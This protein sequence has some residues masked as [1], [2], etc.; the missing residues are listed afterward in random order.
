MIIGPTA[1]GK[2]AL[3]VEM[4]HLLGRDRC[5]VLA[6]D[7]FQIYRGMDIGTAKP[8]ME[9]RRGVEHL[10]IDL[11]D[12]TGRFT[13]HQWLVLA[14]QTIARVQARGG[15]PIVVGGTNLYVKALLDGLFEGPEPNEQL[16][17]QLRATPMARLR[18]ELERVDP[19]AAAKIERNDD[20]RTIRALEVF[21]LT[22]TPISALQQQ[23]DQGRTRLNCVLIGLDWPVPEINGRINAR[24]K[25]MFAQGLEQECRGLLERGK[26]GIQA[27]EALGYKQ[28]IDHFEGRCS[29]AEAGERIKID[30]RRFA[31]QQRTWLRRIRA[32]TANPMLWIDAATVPP[33]DWAPMAVEF[34]RSKA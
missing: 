27:R 14:E 30:T 31:K 25:Q 22:G 20:R 26:L 32:T 7:A 5:A 11:C 15:V 29:P 19:A 6:A 18:E 10:L 4:A 8:T 28:L 23:W 9:E 34:L 17:S 3:A 24:V 21:R 13:V 1:G 33:G 12:P 2:S 16:R